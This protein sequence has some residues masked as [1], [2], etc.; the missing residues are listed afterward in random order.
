MSLPVI[1]SRTL[2][3]IHSTYNSSHLLTPSSN[4]SLL[5]HP[6]T[7]FFL[8]QFRP[9]LG[10]PPPINVSDYG[11]RLCILLELRVENTVADSGCGTIFLAVWLCHPADLMMQVVMWGVTGS[12]RRVVVWAELVSA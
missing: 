11:I 2:L 1:Y 5:H 10:V 8:R 4:L 7:V 3:F 12:S 9:C 6:P